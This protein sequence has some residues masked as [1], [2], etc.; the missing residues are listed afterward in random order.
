MESLNRSTRNSKCVTGIAYCAVAKNPLLI[1]RMSESP[2]DKMWDEYSEVFRDFDDLTLARW[3]SQTL[4]Q[5]QGRIWRLSHPLMGAFRLAAQVGHERQVWL[6]RLAAI[7]NG[8]VEASCCSAPLLPLFTRDIAEA[9]L[10][11]IHCSET[12]VAFDDLPTQL[13]PALR[14]WADDY[15]P[16]HGVAHWEEYQRKNVP[17]YEQAYENA[18][19]NAEKLLVFAGK[20][21]VPQLA[22][23]YT[24]IVW[25]DHDECLEVRPEDLEV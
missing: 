22:E 18:A 6:K 19:Q 12:G 23:F 17:S 8:Y 1:R 9:G 11:C 2:L 24:T 15:A 5:M 14:K 13:Q 4:S 20:K 16:V 10:G 21:L 25:E 3:L 7:P